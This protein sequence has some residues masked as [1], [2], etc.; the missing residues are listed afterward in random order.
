MLIREPHFNASGLHLRDVPQPRSEILHPSN[1]STDSVDN[2]VGRSSGS[3][4]RPRQHWLS[5]DMLRDW[6]EVA[7]STMTPTGDAH[8]TDAE[9]GG[10]SAAQQ[11]EEGIFASATDCWPIPSSASVDETVA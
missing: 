5:R 2:S 9:G 3:P 1:L 8:V 4:A 11:G 7:F 10:T 6:A